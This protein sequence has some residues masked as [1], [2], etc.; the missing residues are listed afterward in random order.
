MM[1]PTAQVAHGAQDHIRVDPGP[2]ERPDE[3]AHG[4]IILR[5]P[6]CVEKQKI[7]AHAVCH[8]I[9]LPDCHVGWAAMMAI[10]AARRRTVFCIGLCVKSMKWR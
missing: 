2:L 3:T 7:A 8:A 4:A 5:L 10:N 6:C 9:I 1:C